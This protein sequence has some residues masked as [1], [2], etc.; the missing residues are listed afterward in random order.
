MEFSFFLAG[1]LAVAGVLAAIIAVLINRLDQP[2]AKPVALVVG[3]I[4]FVVFAWAGLVL[5]VVESTRR[6]HPF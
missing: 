2:Y 6:G 5:V 1:L 3:V 4:L